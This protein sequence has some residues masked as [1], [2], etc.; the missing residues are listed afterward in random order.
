[1]RLPKEDKAKGNKATGKKMLDELSDEVQAALKL[2]DSETADG[3]IGE[4]GEEYPVL[5]QGTR[6]AMAVAWAAYK[7]QGLRQNPTALKY[8]AQTLTIVLTL[9]HYA[10]ALGI[11]RGL[12]GE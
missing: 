5:I 2:L 7:S 9:V 4:P 12:A 8:G 1:M 6:A 10:Y 3:I 11:R